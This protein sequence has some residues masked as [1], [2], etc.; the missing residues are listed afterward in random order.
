MK[1]EI[2]VKEIFYLSIFFTAL[3]VYFDIHGEQNVLSFI[4]NHVIALLIALLV[5]KAIY[6]ILKNRK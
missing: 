3:A 1:L 5:S 6:H 2:G 4:I